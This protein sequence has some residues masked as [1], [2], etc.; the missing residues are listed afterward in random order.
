MPIDLPAL[1]APLIH[2]GPQDAPDAASAPT[3]TSSAPNAAST[4]TV[5]TLEDGFGRLQT[6]GSDLVQSLPAAAVGL[7]VLVLFL[8]A[9]RITQLSVRRYAAKRH[10]HRGLA[11]AAGR[12][13]L[14]ASVILGCLV[15]AVIVFPNFTPTA[16]LTS[17]GVSSLVLGLAFKDVLQN[18]LA[19]I[20]LL[21]AEPFRSGDQ[22]IFREFEG[23]V[24]DVQPRAT[25]IRT[26][27]GRRVVI[28]NAELFTNAVTVNTAF[29]RRRIEYDV[30][31]GYGDDISKAKQLILEAIDETAQALPDPAP[32][33]LVI[34]LAPSSVM[35]RV[36]WW[37]K[38]PV[39]RESFEARDTILTAIKDKLLINGVDLPFPTQHVLFHDQTEESDGDRSRQREGWPAP[40]QGQP[41]L[42]RNV[43]LEV[44]GL[45]AALHRMTETAPPRAD[46]T[47]RHSTRQPPTMNNPPPKEP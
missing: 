44:K 24:E 34:D 43:A 10:K 17:V 32:E 29:E 2:P 20:L 23:T 28:P 7:T 1:I 37:I 45:G 21:F 16:L 5:G 27:D 9:G 36:R 13:F 19:G 47:Q 14:G 3:A 39:I 4:L 8:V 25:F 26:Y 35:L 6:L 11:L 40:H 31:I 46:Q 15:A 12:L 30:G 33:V 22:V 38:P 42:P 41:T 18:Y